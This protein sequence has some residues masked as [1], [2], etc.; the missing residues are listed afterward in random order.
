MQRIIVLG[1]PG[2]GKSTLSRRLGEQ[3]GLPAFHL[4]QAYW[5]AGWIETPADR[6][7]AEVE[8]I[9]GLPAWVIDGN[10][11]ET[12]GPRFAAADTVIYLDVPCWLSVL[13]LLRRVVVGYG[14]VRPDS[15][16]GC[17][18][19][20]DVA[21]L[22]YAWSWNRVRRARSLALVESFPGRKFVLRSSADRRRLLSPGPDQRTAPY[23]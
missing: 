2:S 6:F 17:A 11:S 23:A 14:R 19:H 18:E 4:D 15:A 5:Q 9:A 7:Q 22:R 10:Y 12:I 20:L 21:F 16:P 13:R 3:L 1:P 8:H